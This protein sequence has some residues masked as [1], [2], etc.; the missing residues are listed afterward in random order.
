MVSQWRFT[1]EYRRVGHA[2]P[3]LVQYS[4]PPIPGIISSRVNR[5]GVE[6]GGY[7]CSCSSS[8]FISF[9]YVIRH[10]NSIGV[11]LQ[12]LRRLAHSWNCSL[13]WSGW[14]LFLVGTACLVELY[15]RQLVIAGPK[16]HVKCVIEHKWLKSEYCNLLSTR[17]VGKVFLTKRASHSLN[18]KH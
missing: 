7:F 5:K 6:W 10:S 9:F 4:V 3:K 8:I 16:P 13:E 17:K 2:Q 14:Q 18:T 15:V 12:T 11:G 1:H